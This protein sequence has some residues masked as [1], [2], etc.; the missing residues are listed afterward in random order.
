ME[1]EKVGGVIVTIAASDGNNGQLAKCNI[2][3]LQGQRQNSQQNLK[4]AI[5]CNSAK[6]TLRN[7]NVTIAS[8][9]GNINPP[10]IPTLLPHK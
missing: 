5:V 1:V 7:S 8:S 10:T 2:T 6:N 9:D 3:A 4:S